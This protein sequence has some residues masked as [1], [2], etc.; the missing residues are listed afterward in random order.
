MFHL[1][2]DVL[3]PGNVRDA[4]DVRDAIAVGRAGQRELGPRPVDR[5]DR[6]DQ[7]TLLCAAMWELMSERLGIT[8]DQ[9]MDR[10]QEIDLRDT[11][12]DGRITAAKACP[13]CTR[14]LATHHAHCLYCGELLNVE[15]PFGKLGSR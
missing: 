4:H 9:L 3:T 1:L 10:V 2:K 11:V 15:G 8:E 7:L 6:V 13:K 12:A 14:P 5:V